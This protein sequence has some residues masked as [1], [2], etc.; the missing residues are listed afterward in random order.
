M[1]C[2]VNMLLSSCP[3][4]CPGN[5]KFVTK[6]HLLKYLVPQCTVLLRTNVHYNYT[7]LSVIGIYRFG[8]LHTDCTVC[9]AFREMTKLQFHAPLIIHHV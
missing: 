5:P 9:A 1:V 3:D 7:N 8:N 2:F 6:P 4:G